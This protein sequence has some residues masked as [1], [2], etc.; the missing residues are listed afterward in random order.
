MRFCLSTGIITKR[1][2]RENNQDAVFHYVELFDLDFLEK[3]AALN[4]D[5]LGLRGKLYEAMKRIRSY[6]WLMKEKSVQDFGKKYPVIHKLIDALI[7]NAVSEHDGKI[8]TP[9]VQ[10]IIIE[11]LE[12]LGEQCL[13]L[14]LYVKL[15]GI[16][17]KSF[18]L[19]NRVEAENAHK[20]FETEY[21]HPV[22]SEVFKQLEKRKAHDPVDRKYLQLPAAVEQEETRKARINEAIAARG[23]L[24]AVA[25][26]VAGS[27]EGHSASR[28]V[29]QAL[30]RY[31]EAKQH[32]TSGL[33]RGDI[34]KSV[35]EDI[36][37]ELS[38]LAQKASGTTLTAVLIDGATLWVCWVG[39]TE[40]YLIRQTEKGVIRLTPGHGEVPPE[41]VRQHFISYMGQGLKGSVH[42]ESPTA[43]Q[44]G[45]RIVIASDGLARFVSAAKMNMRDVVCQAKTA[46]EAAETLA[47]KVTPFSDDNITAVVIEVGL[48]QTRQSLPA[49]SQKNGF[50]LL[51]PILS[52]F[53]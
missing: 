11:K 17:L 48:E 30:R 9:E 32:I 16:Q 33:S 20:T 13:D 2:K 35:I 39:D 45:D 44:A 47:E 53:R 14:P 3:Y 28:F 38:H 50:S 36:D 1:G 41:A 29:T 51:K 22:F 31:Y 34:L 5:F 12:A 7:Q 27:H 8:D 24:F 23:Q 19:E 21:R 49:P 43:V 37:D 18:L 46:Q 26:G 40:A 25:D 4:D 10:D 6:E 15:Y 42:L 52:V